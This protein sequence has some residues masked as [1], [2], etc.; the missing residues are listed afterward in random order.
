V[1]L[2][3]KVSTTPF[4]A[5]EHFEDH[6]CQDP[7]DRYYALQGLFEPK[8]RL[9]VDYEK[10]VEQVFVEAAAMILWSCGR[11]SPGFRQRQ[12]VEGCWKLAWRMGVGTLEDLGLVFSVGYAVLAWWWVHNHDGTPLES[13]E[14]TAACTESLKHA[15]RD[16]C[17]CKRDDVTEGWLQRQDQELEAEAGPRVDEL[18]NYCLRKQPSGWLRLVLDEWDQRRPP[19]KGPTGRFGWR[20]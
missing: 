19:M 20:I 9:A 7:R 11:G 8:W 4:E 17:N 5:W 3:P 14:C 12:S 16:A 2:K 1:S 18:N 6:H 10:P 13:D 15:L